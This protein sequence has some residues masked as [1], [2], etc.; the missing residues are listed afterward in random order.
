MN[1]IN[2][3][4]TLII[5][6]FNSVK[7]YQVC[8]ENPLIGKVSSIFFYPIL[9]L[10]LIS[11]VSLFTIILAVRSSDVENN[12]RY[13][14]LIKFL[15]FLQIPPESNQLILILQ[16]GYGFRVQPVYDFIFDGISKKVISRRGI[17]TDEIPF[18]IFL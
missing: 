6:L 8:G 14:I 3:C 7:S 15:F 11:I 5:A 13:I 1:S 2:E 10:N 16:I 9:P 18:H 12:I 17:M 4:E